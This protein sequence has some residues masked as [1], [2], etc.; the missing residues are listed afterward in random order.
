[1][2]EFAFFWNVGGPEGYLMTS[3]PYQVIK[4]MFYCLSTLWLS[5]EKE[6]IVGTKVV[7][8]L[9]LCSKFIIAWGVFDLVI[10]IIVVVMV[11]NW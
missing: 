1:M 10:D 6:E 8:I 7:P 11:Q 5:F 3:T 4:V 9:E 2:K